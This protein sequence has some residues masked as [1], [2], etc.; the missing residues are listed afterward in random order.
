[1]DHEVRSAAI[2]LM[3][4]TRDAAFR[5]DADGARVP[6]GETVVEVVRLP[7]E[8]PRTLGIPRFRRPPIVRSQRKRFLR[9]ECETRGDHW[10]SF[11]VVSL[12]DN[13]SSL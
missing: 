5:G 8:W 12:S 2:S 13:P 9:S 1:M 10:G 4:C 7:S 6:R 3:L 11:S